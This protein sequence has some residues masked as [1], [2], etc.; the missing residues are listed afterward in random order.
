MTE[1]HLLRDL[2]DV[3]FALK[4]PVTLTSSVIKWTFSIWCHWIFQKVSSQPSFT[5]LL[6]EHFGCSKWWVKR[7]QRRN[8]RFNPWISLGETKLASW[9]WNQRSMIA[10]GASFKQDKQM[11]GKRVETVNTYM[12]Y[13]VLIRQC[14]TCI[15]V[16][17]SLHALKDAN[18]VL[19][20]VYIWVNTSGIVLKSY[21]HLHRVHTQKGQRRM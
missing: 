6:V 20:C 3:W 19:P 1:D 17:W 14:R 7:L 8:K 21:F 4:P 11:V 18:Y 15:Y 12:F 10:T 2:W 16:W 9:S 13:H 5:Q